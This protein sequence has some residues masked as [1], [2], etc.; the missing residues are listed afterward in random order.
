MENLSYVYYS[1][2]IRLLASERRKSKRVDEAYRMLVRHNMQ[3]G[4][5]DWLS[6]PFI[7]MAMKLLRS[8]GSNYKIGQAIK[9]LEEAG[10]EATVASEAEAKKKKKR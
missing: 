4:I 1:N 8:F 3:A 2:A 10:E 6:N 5:E 9:L 7:K